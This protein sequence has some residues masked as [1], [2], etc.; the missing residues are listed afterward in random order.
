[1]LKKWHKSLLIEQ[2]DESKVS[3]SLVN[4][5]QRA[6]SEDEEQQPSIEEFK[7]FF[8]E[9][10]LIYEDILEELQEISIDEESVEKTEETTDEQHQSMIEYLTYRKQYEHTLLS[11]LNAIPMHKELKY[12]QEDIAKFDLWNN[13]ASKLNPNHDP[14]QFAKEKDFE[15]VARLEDEWKEQKL[16]RLIET[17]ERLLQ[18]R[19]ERRKALLK[20]R[21]QKAIT[22]D[23]ENELEYMKEYDKYQN[24]L[25]KQS[26]KEREKAV[27]EDGHIEHLNA[28]EDSLNTLSLDNDFTDF[29]IPE[30]NAIFGE[31]MDNAEIDGAPIKSNEEVMVNKEPELP[32][33]SEPEVDKPQIQEEVNATT[34]TEKVVEEKVVTEIKEVEKIVSDPKV[35]AELEEKRKEINRILE[36]SRIQL[37]KAGARYKELQDQN[38]KEISQLLEKQ[39]EVLE[40]EKENFELEKNELEEVIEINKK[41]IDEL[42]LQIKED[43]ERAQALLKEK[44]AIEL[45]ETK[46]TLRGMKIKELRDLADQLTVIYSKGEKKPILINKIME[47]ADKLK[48]RYSILDLNDLIDIK[49]EALK[50]QV[51]TKELSV[52]PF[53]SMTDLDGGTMPGFGMDD[54]DPFGNLDMGSGMD[55][56]FGGGDD[57]FGNIDG[58]SGMDDPF[59]GG[60]DP[61]ANVDTSGGG[62]DP[63]GGGTDPF[64]N[65]DS[66]GGMDD[67]FSGGS[68]PFGNMSQSGGMDDSF[69]GGSDPFGGPVKSPSENTT[70]QP[71]E[72]PRDLKRRLK[73]EQKL[74]KI[75]SKY[76]VKEEEKKEDKTF[77]S[78][79][80]FE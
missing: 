2:I 64:G 70:T 74:A 38:S 41:E 3:S 51:G 10:G 50:D 40:S 57:P 35:I 46:E 49:V 14:V 77:N 11:L 23:E 58:N 34:Q 68:D 65:V 30:E 26:V 5:I 16:S 19:E 37:E 6:K 56:P 59:G 36:N 42:A 9:L 52:D 71:L 43:R 53:A 28:L 63:F 17:R 7:P 55:D 66:S 29:N 12:I 22:K 15:L 1:M 67:E 32:S 48:I 69:G 80:E 47:K 44:E 13:I 18:E 60:S 61:F 8:E 76:G 39:K 24:D 62:D 72:N 54:N 4:F 33:I 31:M 25:Y 79:D 78:F 73:Q 75:R 45:A 21:R 27:E 20:R